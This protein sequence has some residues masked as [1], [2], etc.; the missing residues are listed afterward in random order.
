[1]FNSLTERFDS[2]FRKLKGHGKLN[3]QNIKESMR[4]VRRALL[5][6]DVNFKIV[7]NFFFTSSHE[8]FVFYYS[9]Q[10]V[11]KLQQEHLDTAK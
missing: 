9:I 7:K 8:S 3:E 4:E 6:A 10:V 5:E 11:Q 1:M 2:I